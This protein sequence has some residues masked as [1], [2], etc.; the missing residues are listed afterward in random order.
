MKILSSRIQN[1]LRIY[2]ESSK[3]R[4]PSGNPMKLK[5]AANSMGSDAENDVPGNRM[6]LSEDGRREQIKKEIISEIIKKIR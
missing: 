3:K 6:S 4:Q 1:I 5:S 2:R